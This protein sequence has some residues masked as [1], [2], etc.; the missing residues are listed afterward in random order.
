MISGDIKTIREIDKTIANTCKL[1]KDSSGKD[2]RVYTRIYESKGNPHF[3][4]I[5]IFFDERG[6]TGT[7]KVQDYLPTYLGIAVFT[8]VHVGMLMQTSIQHIL[9]A[10]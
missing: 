9:G 3:K 10:L 2:R 8:L 4:R 1:V 7:I 5:R 6:K